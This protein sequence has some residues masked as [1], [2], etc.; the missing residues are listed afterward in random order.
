MKTSALM[1]IALLPLAACAST[2]APAPSVP[3]P[4]AATSYQDM[5]CAELE[6]AARQQ[7]SDAAWARRQQQQTFGSGPTNNANATVSFPIGGGGPSAGSPSNRSS[8]DRSTIR[9]AMTAKGCPT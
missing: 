9:S 8:Q 4:A 1:I 6:A 2:T 7:S 3:G 5:S